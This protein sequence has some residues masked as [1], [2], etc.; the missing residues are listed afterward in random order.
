MADGPRSPRSLS[1]RRFLSLTA[2]ATAATASTVTG[3]RA[4]A[5]AH[6]PARR[7]LHLGEDHRGAEPRAGPRAGARSHP[8]RPHLLQPPRRVVGRRQAGAGAGRVVDDERRR[9]DVDVQA[10]ARRQVPQRPRVRRRRREVQLRARPRSQGEL[11]WPRLPLGDRRHGDAGQAH[12]AGPHQAAE[13][14]APR[15]HGG[16]L[17]VDHPEG[18]R[19]GEG[20]PPPDGR[21]HR[22]LHLPGVGAPEPP[23]GAEEP[24]LLGQG[25]A[26]R[27]RPRAQGHPGR[28]EHHRPAPHGQRPPRAARGQ[29]ELPP[30]Q[31]RQ[32][33]DRAPR[34]AARLRHGQRSTTGGSPSPTSGCARRSAWPSTGPRCC[35]RPPPASAR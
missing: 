14:V 11:G 24:R 33:A 30:R 29:Q 4:S 17:V 19:R 1:R 22:P 6:A 7:H 3:R 31:G 23:Q 5:Q 8:A 10:P 27:R 25:Q 32:A 18:G 35:R 13:R 34:A 12:A 2:A 9:Q 21:R 15:R 26:V 20:R 16:R 28:G